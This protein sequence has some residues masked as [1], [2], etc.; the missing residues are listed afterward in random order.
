MNFH[1]LV[2]EAQ[3]H[4]G[5]RQVFSI[6]G[7]DLLLLQHEGQLHLLDNI[8]PHAGYPLHQGQI[9]NHALRCPMHGYLFELDG[10]RCILHSEGPCDDLR[11]FPFAIRE[12][13]VGVLL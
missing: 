13:M 6:Q 7:H 2:A 9:I 12:G 11:A 4:E 5:Y 8:C 3:L 10:G 1:P